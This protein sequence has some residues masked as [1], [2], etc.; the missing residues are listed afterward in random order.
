MNGADDDDGAE[1]DEGDGGQAAADRKFEGFHWGRRVRRR[2]NVE[3]SPQPRELAELGTLEAVVYSTT[4]GGQRAHWE[5]ELGE[6]GGRKP[7][8]AVDPR[9]DRLHI[10]GGDYRVEDR[11][12]VD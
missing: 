3:L 5:H 1:D 2:R 6:E 12:I 9:S 11:G 7:I 10:V 4:K 8:L